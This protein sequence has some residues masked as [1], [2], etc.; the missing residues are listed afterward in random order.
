[1]LQ[2]LQNPVHDFDGL[3]DEPI[4]ADGWVLAD[5]QLQEGVADSQDGDVAQSGAGARGE[6]HLDFLAALPKLQ[7]GR[8]SVRARESIWA[9]VES[10]DTKGAQARVGYK[11]L[12]SRQVFP[13]LHSRIWA[14]PHIPR[15]EAGCRVV[16]VF[17]SAREAV[18]MCI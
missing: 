14:L 7:V 12:H 6:M 11:G 10:N 1:M 17:K 4:A 8:V 5:P 9:R 2:A 18:R 13:G 3:P 15:S 16:C